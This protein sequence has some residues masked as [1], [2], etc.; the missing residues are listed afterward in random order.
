VDME[1]WLIRELVCGYFV[2][3]TESLSP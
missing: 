2:T 1:Y 3:Y